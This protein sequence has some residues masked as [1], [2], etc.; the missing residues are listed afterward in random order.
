[1][2]NVAKFENRQAVQQSKT[3][4]QLF[5]D[6]FKVLR[7]ICTASTATIKTDEDLNILREQWVRAFAENGIRSMTQI[8]GGLAEAR[9]KASPFLPSPGQFIEW[10]QRANQRHIGLPTPEQLH[11]EFLTYCK[12]RGDYDSAEDYPWKSD[13]LYWLI[14]DLHWAMVEGRLTDGEVRKKADRL[15]VAMAKRLERGEVI[16]APV[17]RLAPP[18]APAG[19]TPAQELYAKYKKRKEAGLL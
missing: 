3:V 16:P 11:S 5:N 9:R 7:Q 2:S 4:V 18:R 1:M 17:K 19:L 15:L 14:T 6:V 13:A 10:C 12:R 8:D